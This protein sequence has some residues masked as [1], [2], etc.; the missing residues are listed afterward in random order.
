[1]KATYLG[2]ACILLEFDGTSILFD[3]FISGNPLA[4]D[5]TLD[6]L[7]PDYIFISHAHQDHILDVE[8]IAKQSGATLVSNF[9]IITYYQ[10]K[11]LKGLPLNH[12][13]HLQLG[14]IT[15]KYVTAIHSSVFPD[16]TYGGNPG[17]FVLWNSRACVYFA[18]DTALTMDM[19]LIPML[20]P[21]VD[22]AILPIGD[23][24]TMGG[25]EALLA[26]D[27]VQC[28]QVIGC[29]FDTFAPIVVNNKE[30][31]INLFSENGKTLHLP[32]MGRQIEF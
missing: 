1:M 28:N 16:G 18:G 3:P 19:K 24:F 17:G 23:T 14:N 27:F 2:H 8:T 20:C 6:Q 30:E 15:V 5:I 25:Q 4:K 9:E 32:T 31:L 26:A 13:G 11:G 7:M 21:S 10:E 12:G 22:L 29:H